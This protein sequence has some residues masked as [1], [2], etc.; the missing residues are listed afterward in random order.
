[1]ALYVIA[2][3]MV[4]AFFIG[5]MFQFPYSDVADEENKSD[6][7]TQNSVKDLIV[8]MRN[9]SFL[10]IAF[11]LGVFDGMFSTFM[12]WY[13]VEMDQSQATLVIGVANF[14][15]NISAFVTFLASPYILKKIGNIGAVNVSLILNVIAFLTY[16]V[17]HNPWLAVIPE[18]VQFVA[19]ALSMSACVTFIGEVAPPDLAGTAQGKDND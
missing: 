1:M 7:K 8:P 14:F 10:I 12:F 18:I 17:I 15:R 4:I 19:F 13:I 16:S 9:W 2:A 11:F 3:V 6:I 5:M